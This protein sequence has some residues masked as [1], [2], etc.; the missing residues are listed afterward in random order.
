MASIY[1]N[2]TSVSVRSQAFP[3]LA[4][5]LDDVGNHPPKQQEGEHREVNLGSPFIGL[6]L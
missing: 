4:P 3:G 6:G 2:G 1:R 5:L